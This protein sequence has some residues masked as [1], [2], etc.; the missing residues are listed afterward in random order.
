MSISGVVAMLRGNPMHAVGDDGRMALSDHLRELRA[1]LMKSALFLFVF[2]IVG[3]FFYDSASVGSKAIGFSLLDLV[4]GPYQDAVDSLGNKVD[5][6][7]YIS[8]AG[9]PLLLQLKLAGVAAVV[10][11]SP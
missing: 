6:T 3:L 10:F 5:S 8:G 9:G 2:F 1:R 11:S 4:L 7:A